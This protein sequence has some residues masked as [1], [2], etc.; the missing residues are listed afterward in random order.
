MVAATCVSECGAVTVR[1]TTTPT[2]KA[3]TTT[4]AAPPHNSSR[5]RLA[6][7][8]TVTG[9]PPGTPSVGPAGP[10]GPV[11]RFLNVLNSLRVSAGSRTVSG[12]PDR[13]SLA[14]LIVP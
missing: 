9:C 14:V 12:A 3:T 5:R 2:T 13:D 1:N 8:A 10:T 4:A 7:G 6:F 11:R